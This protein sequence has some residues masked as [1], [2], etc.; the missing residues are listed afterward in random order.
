MSR[1]SGGPRSARI[2]VGMAKWIR[3]GG[4]IEHGREEP[5]TRAVGSQRS[6]PASRSSARTSASWLAEGRRRRADPHRAPR[7]PGDGLRGARRACPPIT[8]LY[9]SI[10]CLL[11]YAVFGPSK[12]LVLGPDSALGPMIAVTIAPLMLA[13]GDPAR[14]VMLASMLALIVGAVMILAAVARLGFIADLL[15]KPTQIGYMNGLAL[16]ILVGQ[17]PKLFGFSVDANGVIGEAKAFVRGRDRRRHR[18]RRARGRRRSLIVILVLQRWMPKLP[19]VLIAVVTAIVAVTA[20][21]LV[22]HGVSVV[23][24]LP[25]GFP[26]FDIPRVSVGDI[27]KLIPGALGIALVALVDTI[28]TSS[29]FAARSGQRVPGE[30]G[31][32]RHR[33]G[34]RRGRVL[35]GLP[36]EHQRFA[37]RGGRAGRHEDADGGRGR[38]GGHH[39][40]PAVRAGT[41]EE[42]PATDAGRGRDRRVVLARDLPG[43]MDL[44][45]RRRTE[46]ALSIAAFLAV[47]FLGVLPGIGIAVALS[48]LNVFRRTWWPYQAILGQVEGRPGLPRCELLPGGGAVGGCRHLPVR[49]TADLREHPHVPGAG[50]GDRRGRARAEWIIVAA[51][52]ITD[53]DTTAADMLHELDEWLNARGINL[54]IAEMKD[55]VRRKIDRYELTRT[56]DPAHFFPT[57]RA[58]T[59]AFRDETG[60]RLAHPA[61]T[62]RPAGYA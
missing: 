41:A 40:D 29:A 6:R 49:R 61:D 22:A 4:W 62:A 42:P 30:P 9:T 54:V 10:L 58:A 43:T 39:A 12:I 35:P 56:I 14:A 17:L 50:A 48:I 31:D 46:F 8:G 2:T 55:P 32:D 28:S 36:R 5:P 11:G 21:D 3:R 38:R 16:T 26:P 25:Q 47:A 13:N 60:A 19:A 52:P 24:T 34:E 18:R 15:S 33:R 27:V 45:R 59:K 37:H 7:S 23:G 57:I 53:V 51:E 1:G 20:F 44:F